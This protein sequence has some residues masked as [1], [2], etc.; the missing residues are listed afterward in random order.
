MPLVSIPEAIHEIKQGRM[1][2]VVDDE[3][4]E[5]EGDL[6]MA[7]EH[8]TPQAIN[9]MAREARGLICMPM[10]GSRLDELQVPLM[11]E[12]G[13]S[14]LGTAFTI[15]VEAK[16]KTT[17]GISA[18]DRAATVQA[19]IDRSTRP[20]DLVRPG[21]MFPLRYC[22]GG[23][24]KRAGHTEASVD[25]AKLAG[26]YPAA[27]VCEIMNDDG[28]MA[29]LPDLEQFAERHE[30]KIIS[31][32]DLIEY[33]RRTEKLVFKAAEAEI[34]T[35]WGLWRAV[36]YESVADGEHHLAMVK[37]DVRVGPPPLVR[38]HSECVTGDVF[39][40]RRC[41]CGEQLHLAMQ[42][43]ND[44]GRGIVVY[45][46]RHEGRG[47]GLANKLR[48]YALQEQGLDTVEANVHLGFPPDPRDYGIGAQILVDQ[49]LKKL[50]LLT[51][52]P[53]K[54][55]GLTGFDLEIVERVPIVAEPHQENMR[56]LRTKQQKLGHMLG[57]A[58]AEEETR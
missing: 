36:A 49:G 44:E 1:V 46:R 22:E 30:L 50:R 48:A 20:A 4:R 15:S 54:R 17:T 37:G 7:A 28:S 18:H 13:T 55:V 41:D 2:L 25:L 32:T 51:N 8:V 43:I 21:H 40:S 9:F 31:I 42:R 14:T 23:V 47:I 34:E 56:Y 24:L 19:L 12:H 35:E 6:V 52:N 53:R 5:N 45:L 3:D 38:M 39:S 11:V 58:V 10:L 29:R 57:F 27:V 33:R 26:L 16:G